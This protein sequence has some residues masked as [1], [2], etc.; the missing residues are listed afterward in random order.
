MITDLKLS[1]FVVLIDDN[2]L[3][4]ECFKTPSIL[5][6]YWGILNFKSRDLLGILLEQSTSLT[7][8]N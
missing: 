8:L 5:S 1:V 2:I 3:Y 7:F 4:T 6:F